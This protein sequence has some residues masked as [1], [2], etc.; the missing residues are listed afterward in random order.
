MS[1]GIKSFLVKGSIG[2][3]GAT[4]LVFKPH[5]PTSPRRQ[6]TY[7]LPWNLYA[8]FLQSKIPRYFSATKNHSF[9]C[10]TVFEDFTLPFFFGENAS[11]QILRFWQ[12]LPVPSFH[13]GI[14]NK[15]MSCK[16]VPFPRFLLPFLTI[17][18]VNRWRY[19]RD[20]NVL[21][22]KNVKK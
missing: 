3:D 2:E 16:A 14:F 22:K 18:C 19:I 8:H 12:T 21:A 15:K 7:L 20:G 17:Y 4:S 5:H 6:K 9:V 13:Q 11:L 10:C 1:N